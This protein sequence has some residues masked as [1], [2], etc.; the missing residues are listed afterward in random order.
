MS[1]TEI[2]TEC[3]YTREDEWVRIENTTVRI[4][5]TDFAQDQLGDIV[6]VELPAVGDTI[7]RG[8]PFGTIESVKAASDLFSPV[9]GTVREVNEALADAPEAVNEGP[10]ED[11]W[12]LSVALSDESEL[13]G[14]LDA[15][16]YQQ[17]LQEREE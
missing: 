2:P 14:L 15:A 12:M 4:G 8:E 17:Y 5:V 3:L 16:G 9:S 10:Y 11:G 13:E 7:T 1:E 6:F